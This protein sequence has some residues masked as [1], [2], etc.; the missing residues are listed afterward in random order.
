[1]VQLL[2]PLR[3]RRGNSYLGLVSHCDVDFLQEWSPGLETSDVRDH[4]GYELG[5][6]RPPRY[7]RHHRNFGMQPKG[8]LRWQRLRPQ[9][10]Q[11]G[12]GQLSRI[13]VIRSLST[14]CL[15]RPTFTS[16]APLGIMANVRA[17]KMPSVSLVSGNR[18]TAISV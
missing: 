7:V 11:C 13:A 6:G 2:L 18:Q 9:G 5:D 3:Q 15:P 12:V 16:M 1:N 8:A 14:T 10:V 4:L 17:Q